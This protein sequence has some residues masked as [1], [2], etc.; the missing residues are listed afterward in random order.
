MRGKQK[1]GWEK[2]EK[3]PK[4]VVRSRMEQ[5]EMKG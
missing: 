2:E 3:Q 5:R 1:K 4:S